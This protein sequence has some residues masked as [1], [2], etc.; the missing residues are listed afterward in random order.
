M[1]CEITMYLSRGPESPAIISPGVCS[2]TM[3]LLNRKLEGDLSITV[4]LLWFKTITEKLSTI[5]RADYDI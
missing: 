1:V 3:F 4:S 2:P 5:S